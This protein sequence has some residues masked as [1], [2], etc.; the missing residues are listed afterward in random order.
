MKKMLIAIATFTAF[1]APA[2]CSAAPPHPG[3]YASGFVGISAIRNT[4]V[5]TVANQTFQD[6]VE[7]DPGLF[8]GGTGGYD[9]GFL[10]M[11]GELSYK[12][13]NINSI[14][15]QI[16]NFQ[17][18]SPDGNIGALAMMFNAFFDLHNDSPITPYVG[19]G[20]GFAAVH[21]SDTYATDPLNG[22]QLLYGADDDTVFAYQAGAGL[23]FA[24]NRRLSLD[25][26]YRYFATDTANFNS[27][28]A[29]AISLKLE[30]H[31]AALGFRV[32]F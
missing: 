13:A 17:F 32:K 25:L 2:V 9:F 20:I 12:Y 4:D 3:P 1:A 22:R 8:I 31:N 6:R 11:E 10:R 18:I 27:N 14:N 28:P 15:D 23:E 5:T 24:I 19:G 21:L 26:G 30:S 16:N 29:G 7:L